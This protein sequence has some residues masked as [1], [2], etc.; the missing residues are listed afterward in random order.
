MA[1]KVTRLYEQFHPENYKIHITLSEDKQSFTGS[2]IMTGQRVG[3]PSK[4]ITL[5]TKDLQTSNHKVIRTDKKGA[6]EELTLSRV[7]EQKTYDELRLHFDQDIFPAKF[8]ISMDF[9]GKITDNMDGIYPCYFEHD[10]KQ[11]RLIATQFESHHAREAFPCIDEPE[12]KAT[13]DFTLTHAS[14]ETAIANTPI[15]DQKTNGSVTTTT[16]DTTPI[17]STYLMA[18]AVGDIEFKEATSKSGIK[19]RTYAT[20]AQVQ[21]TDFALE[22]AV[23]CMDYLRRRH[24]WTIFIVIQLPKV[25]NIL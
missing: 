12:A 2:V 20:P 17:M 15:V 25:G 3:K 6:T 4:R 23:K 22:F 1:K 13:F 21:Y 24:H 5:H 14:N 7:N 9:E 11:K 18:F 8:E 16:Y 10:G 19:I